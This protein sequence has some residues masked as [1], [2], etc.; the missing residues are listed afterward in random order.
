MAVA[1]RDLMCYEVDDELFPEDAPRKPIDFDPLFS[2]VSSVISEYDLDNLEFFDPTLFR[3]SPPS[4]ETIQPSLTTMRDPFLPF[5]FAVPPESLNLVCL[6]GIL[7]RYPMAAAIR[8]NLLLGVYVQLAPNLYRPE[9]LPYNRRHLSNLVKHW[10]PHNNPYP[11]TDGVGHEW[12]S[13]LS[14]GP[15][16]P[17]VVFTCRVAADAPIF[18]LVY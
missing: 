6:D 2:P 4:V 18:I 16:G 9:Q 12:T 10:R 15:D 14:L 17:A 5:T 1:Q 7:N 13:M 11:V 8:R 3:L